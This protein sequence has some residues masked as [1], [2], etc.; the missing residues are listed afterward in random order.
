MKS[1]CILTILCSIMV[2]FLTKAMDYTPPKDLPTF[3]KEQLR[4]DEKAQV[5]VRQHKRHSREHTTVDILASIT[6]AEGKETK[7]EI[8]KDGTL[9]QSNDSDEAKQTYSKNFVIGSNCVSVV[10]TALVGAGVAIA[11]KY[12]ECPK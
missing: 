12:G 3:M 7:L 8:Q 10:C 11:I 1:I 9:T 6:D 4:Q 2:Y 5:D